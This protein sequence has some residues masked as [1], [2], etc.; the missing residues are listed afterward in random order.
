MQVMTR[1]VCVLHTYGQVKSEWKK[2]KRKFDQCKDKS[3]ASRLSLTAFYV[4][5]IE[6]KMKE[7]RTCLCCCSILIMKR[8]CWAAVSINNL[9]FIQMNGLN[10]WSFPKMFIISRW[11]Q[12][13]LTICF[14]TFLL[15]LEQNTI[16]EKIIY[17]PPMSLFMI[18][19]SLQLENRKMLNE[20][21]VL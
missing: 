1:K 11:I 16:A 10:R 14:A 3:P 18:R 13:K 4:W 8:E 9:F 21:Y 19:L 5:W 15:L 6:M 20:N 17:I 2:K 12:P 7:Y